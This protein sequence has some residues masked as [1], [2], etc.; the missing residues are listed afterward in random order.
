MAIPRCEC[1]WQR[2]VRNRAGGRRH[3]FIAGRLGALLA[4]GLLAFAAARPAAAAVAAIGTTFSGSVPFNGKQVP[5]PEGEWVLAGDGYQV[6]PSVRGGAGDVVEDIVLLK[7]AGKRVAAFVLAH[8]NVIGIDQ[9]WGAGP[10]CERDDIH[11][12]VVYDDAENHMFCGFV[13][14]VITSMEDDEAEHVAAS[15]AQ[16]LGYV[17]KHELTLPSTWLMA[18][19]RKSDQ[20]DILDVRYHFEPALDGL[21]PEPKTSWAASEWSAEAVKGETE[22]P[23]WT[24]TMAGWAASA[25]FWRAP[26]PP[27]ALTPRQAAVDSLVEWLGQMRYVVELG[28]ENRVAQAG[29][30]PMPWTVGAAH[31][32]PAL[33]VR[34]DRLDAVRQSGILSQ[35]LYDRER[36]IIESEH[37]SVASLRWSA[38]GITNIKA[39][40]DSATSKIYGF[41]A[42]YLFTGNVA[43]TVSLLGV[44]TFS[45][46]GQYWGT[47]YLWNKLGPNAAVDIEE[48]ELNGAGVD[49]AP[50]ADE[51][52]VAPAAHAPVAA[53]ELRSSGNAQPSVTQ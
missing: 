27:P 26:A 23:G 5:L 17:E 51:A 20:F 43:T 35:S 39:L 34:L 29:A 8:R 38:E 53:A 47:E 24:A 32:E 12:A 4:I 31:F 50:E 25:A 6:I 10:D 46:F 22:Q 30:V 33:D 52:P 19:F 42:D 40:T 7:L 9:G 37:G 18:G 41:A 48:V 11:L 13:N 45:D 15:W 28:Y 44:Q 3:G 16:A 36:D 14:H 21:P 2:H 1:R 49:A